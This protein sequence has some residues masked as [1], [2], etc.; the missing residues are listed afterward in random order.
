MDYFQPYLVIEIF[1]LLLAA[2]E[3]FIKFD[4]NS[5]Q[6]FNIFV[7]LTFIVFFGF[8]GF[9]GWD[10]HSYYPFYK[11]LNTLVNLNTKDL[12]FDFGFTVFAI[13]IKTISSDYHF[14]IF[15]NTLIDF[16][17]LHIFFKRYLPANLY[18]FAFAVF[19]VM[20]GIVFEL[21]LL[22]NF[23][24]LL[25]FMISIRYL[26]NRKIVP[27]MILNLIGLSFHW[28]SVIFFPL[29][30]FLHKKIDLRV[31]I[32]ITIIGNTIYL[33]Q[34]EFIKPFVQFIS[35]YLGGTVKYKTDFY[36]GASLYNQTYGITIGY[37][38]RLLTTVLILIYY[39]KLIEKSASNII[40][41]NCFFVYFVFFFFFSEISILVSRLARLFYFSYWI[42]WPSLIQISNNTLKYLLYV[43]LAIFLNLKI[44]KATNNIFYKYD[45]VAFGQ[46]ESFKERNQIFDKYLKVLQ[47]DN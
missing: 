33:L 5:I 38:E 34:I 16:I 19:I 15:V 3:I 20:G 14:F 32:I 42:L 39:N 17:L 24:G 23:K 22:R 13:S 18:A 43:P 8:R 40:F 28:S 47:K 6:I 37:I 25:L 4:K 7:G 21:D 12:K 1:F 31:F 35:T 2:L 9:I 36:L 45:N 41:I 46:Y 26:E 44:I 27:Y 29:Y 30:F 10:W 11:D